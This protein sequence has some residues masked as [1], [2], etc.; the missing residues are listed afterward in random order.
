MLTNKF[1]FHRYRVS[2]ALDALRDVPWKGCGAVAR[3][4]AD[5]L[6]LRMFSETPDLSIP[7]MSIPGDRTKR[8][9]SAD[10]V[11]MTKVR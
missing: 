10:C 7:L 11:A 3:N 2:P 6:P 5:A 8:V 9:E 4:A 1:Y